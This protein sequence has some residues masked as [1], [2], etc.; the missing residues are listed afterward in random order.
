MHATL[1]AT[2]PLCGSS[3]R[4]WVTRFDHDVFRCS[5]GLGFV[6]PLPDATTI[7][8]EDYFTGAKEGF[9]YTEYDRDKEPMRPTF[10]SFIEKFRTFAPKGRLLD[11][12]AATGFF[13]DIARK[14]GYDAEGVEI[15]AYA[16]EEGRKK[17]LVMFTGTLSSVP[18]TN[19]YAVI[20]MFDLIEHVND[21]LEELRSAAALLVPQGIL[22]IN[23]P[24]FSSATARLLGKHWHAIVPPEHLYYYT[25]ANITAFLERAGFTVLEISAPAKRFTLPYI[26]KTA[27]KW[28]GHSL[29]ETL[30]EWAMKSAIADRPIPL[31]LYDNAFIIARKK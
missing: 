26:F 15:S 17:G 14:E 8:N 27:K 2:C 12:G 3:A 20:T 28:T 29:F 31:N 25:R 16:A 18:K 22:V 9:G 11:V 24:D 21:P 6:Y 13:A 1:V 19:P 5:C 23:I 10:V 30:E 7:Y 4:L